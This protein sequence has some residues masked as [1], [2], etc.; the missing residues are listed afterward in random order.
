MPLGSVRLM[1]AGV[2]VMLCVEKV[3]VVYTFMCVVY[4]SVIFMACLNV[5]CYNYSI[6]RKTLAV[7]KY[8][9]FPLFKIWQKNFGSS[10]I[11]TNIAKLL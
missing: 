8:D 10:V 9:K 1:E 3:G 5:P 6:V 2:V 7:K 4:S 11:I